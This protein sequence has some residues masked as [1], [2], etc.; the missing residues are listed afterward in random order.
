MAEGTGDGH[1]VVHL[2][3]WMIR[4]VSGISVKLLERPVASASGDHSEKLRVSM[5]DPRDTGGSRAQPA[6]AWVLSRPLGAEGSEPLALEG[7]WLP[8]GP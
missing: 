6:R 7:G 4:W 5:M 8:P 3:G 1:S 2:S